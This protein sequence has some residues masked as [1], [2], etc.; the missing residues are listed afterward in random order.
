VLRRYEVEECDPTL[1]RHH[2][3]RSWQTTIPFVPCINRRR[4]ATGS[5]ICLKQWQTWRLWLMKHKKLVFTVGAGNFFIYFFLP[6]RSCPTGRTV[7][8]TCTAHEFESAR[9]VFLNFFGYDHRS[10]GSVFGCSTSFQGVIWMLR[11]TKPGLGSTFLHITLRAI[12]NLWWM[13]EEMRRHLTLLI[14][15]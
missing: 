15:Y 1:G 2:D 4:K 11:L 13:Q 8:N 12:G 10:F 3:V 7:R 9:K 14:V 6:R 5:G